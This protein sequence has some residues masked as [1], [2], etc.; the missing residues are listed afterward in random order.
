MVSITKVKPPIQLIVKYVDIHSMNLW[1]CQ[2][3]HNRGFRIIK[4]KSTSVPWYIFNVILITI[5]CICTCTTVYYQIYACTCLDVIASAK[6]VHIIHGIS[7][8]FTFK[9]MTTINYV[10]VT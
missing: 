6:H 3:P 10:H 1:F 2:I 8:Y 5:T 7:A 9:I 4:F